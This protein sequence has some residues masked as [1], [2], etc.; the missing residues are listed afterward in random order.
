MLDR[1]SPTKDSVNTTPPFGG[2]SQYA[3]TCEAIVEEYRRSRISKAI[4]SRSLLERV[5]KSHES[6][7]ERDCAF[8]DFFE[9]LESDESI[10]DLRRS[11]ASES[12][13]R[14]RGSPEL[15]P[16]RRAEEDRPAA[17]AQPAAAVRSD[18]SLNLRGRRR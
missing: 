7:D 15:C 2:A 13:L 10:D 1:W 9:R 4:A 11:G 12:Q 5:I 17:P 8:A 14:D 6:P 16:G 3:R 18:T